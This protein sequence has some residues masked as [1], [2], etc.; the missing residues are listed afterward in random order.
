MK[1]RVLRVHSEAG[2]GYF[3]LDISDAHVAVLEAHA[4][5]QNVPLHVAIQMILETEITRVHQDLED[6]KAAFTLMRDSELLQLRNAFVG[7]RDQAKRERRDD[8]MRFARGRLALI[9]QILAARG[10]KVPT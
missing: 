8:T 6:A 4:A 5:A 2:G 1:F 7:D 3:L 9:D 10:V